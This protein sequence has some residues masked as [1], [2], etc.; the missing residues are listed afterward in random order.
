VKTDELGPREW[1]IVTCEYAPTFGGIS[2]Y[3][4]SI[5]EALASKG[6]SVHVW[7]PAAEGL[8]PACPGVSVHQ[9]L[10]SFDPRSVWRVGRL[11][12]GHPV[13]RRLFVQWVPH[14]F[15]YKSLNLPFALWLAGRAWFR[16]D[17]LHLMVHEPYLRF[18]RKP[19]HI[20]ASLIHRL[21]LCLAASK[22]ERIWLSTSAW[23]PF[24]KPYASR[25]RSPQWLPVPVPP[26][27]RPA[28]PDIDALRAELAPDASPLVGHFSSH[29]PILTPVLAPTIERLLR[30]SQAIMV[31][32]GHDGHRLRREI[33]T[34]HPEFAGRIRATG[35]LDR[36]A[37]AQH[38]AACDLMLQPYPDGISARRTSTITLLAEGCPIVTNS[39]ALTESFWR[40]GAV[41]LA[42]SP[43][44]RQIAE[45]VLSLL[46]DRAERTRCA[47]RG[48]QLYDRV[49]DV[50]HAVAA[51]EQASRTPMA[52]AP[53]PV[54]SHR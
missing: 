44:P 2:D 50:R 52:Y 38:F 28:V 6:V 19:S 3:A 4:R 24:V 23:E 25:S 45:A 20:V 48:R 16:D 46:D 12:N 30:K 36:L 11:L 53:E 5:A 47:E 26:T 13:R 43:D 37:L 42:P 18:S 1:H 15:G 35:E 39:G 31:L 27:P 9:E 22:A 10:G 14:G 8:P 34:A 21:M 41:V 54:P 29:S 33:V 17:E 7:C 32:I 51:L 49:F 40:E